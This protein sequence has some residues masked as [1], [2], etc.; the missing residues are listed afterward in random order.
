MIPYDKLMSLYDHS[1]EANIIG[2]KLVEDVCIEKD[3]RIS[4]LLKLDALQR[5]KWF[6]EEY[7]EFLLNVPIKYVASFLG[8]KRETISRIRKKVM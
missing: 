6:M 1:L 5:Y 3:I 7:P 4:K 8:M 2:R